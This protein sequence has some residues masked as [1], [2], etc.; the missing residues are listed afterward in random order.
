ML[1]RHLETILFVKRGCESPSSCFMHQIKY[2]LIIICNPVISP[3]VINFAENYIFKRVNSSWFVLL[4]NLWLHFLHC[5]SV[6][7][8]FICRVAY[9]GAWLPR[10][11][12]KCSLKLFK[13]L[14]LDTG[15]FSLIFSPNLAN[16]NSLT[17]IKLL[18][19]KRYYLKTLRISGWCA[20][21][22]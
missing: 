20:V 11:F 14:S 17:D 9:K 8:F 6:H 2:Q 13:H 5:P 12:L 10:E 7:H 1:K 15:C 21:C 16:N 18:F 22:P 3:N 19:P 4:W